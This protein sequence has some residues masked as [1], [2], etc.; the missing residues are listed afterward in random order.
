[1]GISSTEI[2]HTTI[3]KTTPHQLTLR[4]RSKLITTNK[5]SQFLILTSRRYAQKWQITKTFP[6]QQ[7]VRIDAPAS[8]ARNRY[9]QRQGGG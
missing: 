2:T 3:H 1:V 5:L 7:L 4:Q 9:L 6:H 8:P